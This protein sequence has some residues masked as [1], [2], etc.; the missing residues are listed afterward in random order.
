MMKCK[1]KMINKI[2]AKFTVKTLPKIKLDPNYEAINKIM[3]LLITNA[4]TLPTSRGRRN[5]VHIGIIMKPTIYTTLS[6]TDWVDPPDLVVYPM[7]LDNA[8]DTHRD[9]LQLQHDKGR[10]I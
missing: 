8:N 2:A 3:P 4:A 1:P 5:D 6:T 10:L 7:F 9:Q